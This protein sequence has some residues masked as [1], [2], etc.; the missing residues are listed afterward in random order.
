MIIIIIII[1]IIVIKWLNVITQD[2]AGQRSPLLIV[3]GAGLGLFQGGSIFTAALLRRSSHFACMAF[4][5]ACVKA[6][7]LPALPFLWV[8]LGKYLKTFH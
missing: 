4:A 7:L 3:C 5:C 6:F 8:G 2:N 1:I